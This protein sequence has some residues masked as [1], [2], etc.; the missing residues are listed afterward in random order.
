MLAVGP[1]LVG[2]HGNGQGRDRTDGLDHLLVVVASELHL[3][4]VEAVG[5]LT[6]LLAHHLGR[7][8]ADGEGG[9]RRLVLVQPPEFIPGRLQ[10]LA[11]E[12]VQGDVHRRLGRRVALRK[13][14]DVGQNVLH[15]EGVGEPTYRVLHFLQEGHHTVQRAQFLLEVGRHGC[16]AIADD[17]VVLQLHLHVGR[18]AARVGG[19]GKYMAQLQ[20]VREEAQLHPRLRT[21]L[22]VQVEPCAPLLPSGQR[23]VY[24]HA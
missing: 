12:V 5:A 20:F 14:V 19:H 16:F 13:A 15:L 10:Q 11:H 17:A 4:D 22:S 24:H 1:P 21:T 9:R 23:V 8:D 6:R 7:I 18:S 3:E 2:V